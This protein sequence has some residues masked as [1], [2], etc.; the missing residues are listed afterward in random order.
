MVSPS[1]TGRG[2]F[3][4]TLQIITGILGSGKT[5]CLRHLLEGPGEIQ[6]GVVVGE[7]AEDGFDGGMIEASGA[8]VRQITATGR[9]DQAKS[10]LDPVRAF[11][12][13]GKFGRVFIETSGVT[14]IAQVSSELAADPVIARS[15]RFAPT[16]VVI[17]AGAFTVHD[18]HFAPQLWAQLDVADVVV[19][20]KTDKAPS[21]SLDAIK[22]RIQQ[23]NDEA[24]I[25]YTYM[26]QVSRGTA[27]SIPYEEFTP[28]AIRASWEGSLPAE[29]EAFVYRTSRVCYDRLMFGHKLLNLPGGQIARFKGILR[30]WDGARSING[31]PGQ[32][33]WDSTPVTGD[34]RIAF[35]GIGLA[36]REQEICAL[37]D[38]ELE[39]QRDEMRGSA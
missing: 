6:A 17:D 37:L 32:L 18:T 11:V 4:T 31:L 34:T 35:I 9:G 29:F 13:E 30:C 21:A 16:I 22:R 10:Y 28:R 7:Y 5:T 27:M 25:V 19:I 39:R 23:R 2:R 38:A 14:E 20:N 1:G 26:G 24:R 8:M 12:E 3:M 36:A 33:D 15:A